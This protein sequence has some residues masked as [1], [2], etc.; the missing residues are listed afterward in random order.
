VGGADCVF[1]DGTFWS[2]DELIGQKLGTRRAEEMA[3]WPVGGDNGS[4]AWLSRA[5]ARRKIL[6]HVNNT[7]PLLRDE[8]PERA[9]AIGAGVEIAH[10]G[11]EIDL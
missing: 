1:W 6:I 7:N 2:S 11:L 4:L 8:S 5:P 3:H 9:A 10:D